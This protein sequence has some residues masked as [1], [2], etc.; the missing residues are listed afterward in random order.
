MNNTS[1]LLLMDC[2]EKPSNHSEPKWQGTKS[3]RSCEPSCLGVDDCV[4]V[5]RGSDLLAVSE[6]WIVFRQSGIKKGVLWRVSIVSKE[7]ICLGIQERF[8]DKVVMACPKGEVSKSASGA[9][10][11]VLKLT[12]PAFPWAP[13]N[14]GPSEKPAFCAVSSGKQETPQSKHCPSHWESE[15]YNLLPHFQTPKDSWVPS[16]RG[17]G[18]YSWAQPQFTGQDSAVCAHLSYW[19]RG[20]QIN[21]L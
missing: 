6:G 10:P 3:D 14:S 9:Q 8:C 16:V 20:A 19:G 17:F 2:I 1:S 4:Q 13:K 11:D 15:N 21:S 18:R 5:S 12:I 7:G